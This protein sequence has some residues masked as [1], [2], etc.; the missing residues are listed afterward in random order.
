MHAFSEK[1]RDTLAKHIAEFFIA[2]HSI[3]LDP[4]I[5]ELDFPHYHKSK[6]TWERLQGFL[7][8]EKNPKILAFAEKLRA[9]WND[10]H[11]K[12]DDIR[13]LHNDLFFK[14]IICHPRENRLS[15]IIDFSDTFYGDFILDF[16]ALYFEDPDFTEKIMDIYESLS[17]IKIRRENVKLFA[18]TFALNELYFHDAHNKFIASLLVGV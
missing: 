2:I 11:E 9:G 7:Q 15:G 5:K 4:E 17:D 1:E 10:Y 16:V 14:N 3:S 18:D 8:E 12:I 13:L 6:H